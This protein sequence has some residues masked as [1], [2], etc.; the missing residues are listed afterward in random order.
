[1]P[2][3]Y[4]LLFTVVVVIPAVLLGFIRFGSINGRGH[5]SKRSVPM[6]LAGV[7]STIVLFFVNALIFWWYAPVFAGAG[8]VTAVT[9]DLVIVAA[10]FGVVG[11]MNKFISF[12]AVAS[13]VIIVT[14]LFILVGLWNNGPLGQDNAKKLA[15]LIK[16]TATEEQDATKN[17]PPTDEKHMVIVGAQNAR[18]TAGAAMGTQNIGTKF[19]LGS[20][21]LQSI[22]GHMY[23][24]YELNFNTLTA[25]NQAGRIVP[26]YIQVDAE[27]PNVAAVIKQG[28]IM[29][30]YRG[31]PFDASIDRLLYGKYKD[32]F[33]DDLSLE[34]D[35]DGNPF[36]T[37]ALHK[38]A[39]RWLQSVPVKTIVINPQNG[40]IDEYD[41]DKAPAWVDRSFSAKTAKD[42]LNW[43]G[44]Y[45]N[46]DWAFWYEAPANRFQVSGELNLVYTDQGPAWQAL[47]SSYN[48]DVAV[49]Y[50]AL[51]STRTLDVRLYKAPP[52]L[53]VEARV[54]D[55]FQKSSNNLK[56]LD[57][58]GLALHKV[59]GKLVWVAGMVPDGRGDL[60]EGGYPTPES[61]NGVGLLDATNSD[62]SLVIIGANKADAFGKLSQQIATGS[63][64]ADPAANAQTR[65]VRGTVAATTT[66][67][68]GGNTF[69]LIR[70]EGD[71]NTTYV[72][73]IKTSD[74]ATLKRG[75]L[76]QGDVIIIGYLDTGGKSKNIASL[77]FAPGGT[78]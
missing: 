31:G 61:F 40:K 67:V 9:I 4:S 78:S 60:E 21:E 68:E 42:L 12:T 58:T 62:A 23:Y 50:V 35:D 25:A 54:V 34:V 52:N 37:A 59:Y 69:A 48:N 15:S 32:M 17:Y 10:I 7:I 29:R 64:N 65:T 63:S 74:E 43:W 53:L 55:A 44:Q 33:I 30:Y 77:D 49:Q 5:S 57:P 26:G 28:Y 11:L 38:T 14:L 41:L 1:M 66:M 39:V 8:W 36:Y 6:L 56:S 19:S 16:V 2:W 13:L 76:K 51:M 22:K 20:G 3:L 73:P 18:L 24:V 72:G 47:M 75:L 71:P 70:L 27:D 45:G 46:A